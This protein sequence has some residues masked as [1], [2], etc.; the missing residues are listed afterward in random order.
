MKK[1]FGVILFNLFYVIS[2]IPLVFFSGK[3]IFRVKSV[4]SPMNWMPLAA[5]IAL[6]CVFSLINTKKKKKTN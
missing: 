1:N 5:C 6:T 3:E 4:D 2:M